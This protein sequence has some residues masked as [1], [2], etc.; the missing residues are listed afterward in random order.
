MNESVESV[1]KFHLLHY[2]YPELLQ[3][4]LFIYVSNCISSGS[5]NFEVSI[6]SCLSCECGLSGDSFEYR[7]YE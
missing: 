1:S 6:R 5:I 2:S 4:S 3:I 7:T